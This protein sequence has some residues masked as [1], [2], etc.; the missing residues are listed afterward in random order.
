MAKKKTTTQSVPL[1]A[2]DFGSDTIRVMAAEYTPEKLLRVLGVEQ[3]GDNGKDN[4]PV[5]RGII[6]NSSN[7]GYHLNALLKKLANRIHVENLP[8]AFVCVGGRTMN[9]AP[10]SSK[11]NLVRRSEV[12]QAVLDDMEQ[13]CKQKI[14]LKNPS[15]VVLDLIPVRYVLDGVEQEDIPTP[16]QRAVLVEAHYTAFVGVKELE[17]KILDSFARSSKML[18]HAYVRPDALL[19]ALTLD[20]DLSKGIALLD[21]GAQTTTLTLFHNYRYV[22][23]KVIPTGGYDI[24]RDIEALGMS[25]NYAENVKRQ[26]GAASPRYVE[27]NY[28]LRIPHAEGQAEDVVIDCNELAGIIEG[29]LDQITQPIVEALKEFVGR[30]DILYVT[31]G[32][33]MLNGMIPYLQNRLAVPVQYGSHAGFLTADTD[34]KMC[35]PT[36]SSLIGTLLLGADYREKHPDAATKMTKGWSL[37]KALEK[38]R[39]KTID[40]FT[41]PQDQDIQQPEK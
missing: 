9:I 21:M 11:R 26:Y 14:E 34:D 7:A 4:L 1:V 37:D 10:I 6:T 20:E 5:E 33:A 25:L 18:E 29:R 15:A 40:L 19:C 28:R 12:T 35:E 38:L 8:S 2:V 32:G 31:G 3:V 13:E 23:N 30:I 22:L 24:A 41:Y 27:K 16:K 36:Y 17:Q 39:D